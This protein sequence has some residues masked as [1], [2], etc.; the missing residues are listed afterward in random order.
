MMPLLS[1]PPARKLSE[2]DFYALG[3][4]RSQRLRRAVQWLTRR[5]A[6]RPDRLTDTPPCP[7]LTGSSQSKERRRCA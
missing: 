7:M 4:G 1:P 3:T 2:D 6:I 5:G